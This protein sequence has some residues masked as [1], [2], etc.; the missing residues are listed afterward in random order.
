MD[1]IKI[2]KYQKRD[3]DKVT[4]LFDKINIEIFGKRQSYVESGK[5]IPKLYQVFYVAEDGKKIIGTIGLNREKKRI[6]K[7]NRFYIEDKFRK[8]GIGLRLYRRLL[9]SALELG[10]K[11]LFLVTHKKMKRA[12]KFYEN[13]GFKRIRAKY[14]SIKHLKKAKN[15]IIFQKR[16]K[17]Q[18][19]LELDEKMGIHSPMYLYATEMTSEYYNKLKLH[20]KKI[21]SIVGS[22]DQIID[23]YFYGAKEVVGFDINKYA[24]YFTRFKIGAIKVL[25]YREFLDFFGTG[26]DDAHLGLESYIKFRNYLNA[27]VKEFFDKIY[28][29]F[30]F[31]GQNI[32]K[33]EFFRQR[34]KR[35]RTEVVGYLKN[36]KN[37]NKLKDILSKKKT[38]LLNIELKK[39][40]RIK[41]SF[42][43]INLSNSPNY[44][45]DSLKTRKKV[46][47]FDQ[48]ILV[49]LSKCLTKRGIIFFYNYARVISIMNKDESIK[50]LSEIGHFNVS[51]VIIKKSFNKDGKDRIIILSRKDRL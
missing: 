19:N 25:N 12:I 3:A 29:N 50:E 8:Q 30:M 22:G 23:A 49:P 17:K 37:Y 5:D 16:I 47:Y 11:K 13:E 28:Q 24:L 40:H 9:T 20:G 42:D 35:K 10:F 14:C 36:A 38:N 45:V 2:R 15:S 44:Y 18:E 6:G 7:I 21:L 34:E 1:R 41:N 43:V 33:S 4:K 32:A 48:K 51:E 27:E 26:R 39:I 31:E 46:V